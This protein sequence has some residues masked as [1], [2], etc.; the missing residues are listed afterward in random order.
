[1]RK[2]AFR[3]RCPYCGMG[4]PFDGWFGMREACE[5]CGFKF[6]REPGYFLG[7]IY[8]NYGVTAA[9]GLGWTFGWMFAGEERWYVNIL[10]AALFAMTFPLWFLRYARL[11]WIAFDLS[12]DPA[13]D[14]DF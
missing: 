13:T 7:S 3:L 12:W 8:L 6:E 9:V 2:R 1:M 14:D 4:A 11:L 5:A 10:P